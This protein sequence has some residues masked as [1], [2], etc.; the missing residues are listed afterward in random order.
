M[1]WEYQKVP[2]N[3]TCLFESLSRIFKYSNISL[4]PNVSALDLQRIVSDRVRYR[5]EDLAVQEWFEMWDEMPRLNESYSVV[6][7]LTEQY[8]KYGLEAV[9]DVIADRMMRPSYWGNEFVLKIIANHFKV[10]I[11]IVGKMRYPTDAPY[12]YNLYVRLSL[13]RLHYEPLFYNRQGIYSVDVDLPPVPGS[14]CSYTT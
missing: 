13:K 8:K 9:I 11:I 6:N 7:G 4:F 10:N 14:H 1:S 3:G 12:P 5:H 2:S